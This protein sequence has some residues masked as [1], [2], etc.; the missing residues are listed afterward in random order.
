ML[1]ICFYCIN[2]VLNTMYCE[3]LGWQVLHCTDAA[4]CPGDSQSLKKPNPYG[5]WYD[6]FSK[7]RHLL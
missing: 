4:Y 3:P 6:N 2:N 1:I 5:C 7:P